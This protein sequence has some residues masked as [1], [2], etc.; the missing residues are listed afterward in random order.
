MSLSD[1]I[2]LV[3]K[4]YNNGDLAKAEVMVK[5]LINEDPTLPY[6]HTLYGMIL[7]K[8]EKIDDEI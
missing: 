7:D 2:K 5:G 1:K 3:E 8:L 6:L 4:E